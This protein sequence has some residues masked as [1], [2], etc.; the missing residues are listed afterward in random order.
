[1]SNTLTVPLTRQGG[2]SPLD[3][4]QITITVDD[5]SGAAVEAEEELGIPVPW[6]SILAVEGE[7]TRDNSP[8]PRI[9]PVNTL[10]WGELPIPFFAMGEIVGEGHDGQV[11]VGRI[12][13]IERVAVEDF[14]DPDFDL[15]RVPEG[16]QIIFARG[17]IQ[18]NAT[19]EHFLTLMRDKALRGVSIDMVSSQWAIA[20]GE[21]LEPVEDEF[22][23]SMEDVLS[24]DYVLALQAAEIG[25][26]TATPLQGIGTASISLT[27]AGVHEA[28][29]ET[30]F[31]IFEDAE[32]EPPALVAAAPIVHRRDAF[33]RPEPDH[34]VP[35][36]VDGL[37]VYGHAFVWD[38][39]HVGFQ[40]TCQKPKPS[41]TGYAN[42]H[43][44]R[45]STLEGEEVWVGQVTLDTDHAVVAP[46]VTPE[47]VW[48]HYSNTGMAVADV[49]IVDGRIGGWV[50][51][52]M[53]AVPDKD[54]RTLQAAK[55]SGD[56]RRINGSLD[57]IGL[58]AVNVPGFPVPQPQAWLVASAAGDE[59]Q[60]MV[61]AG[62]PTD[63]DEMDDLLAELLDDEC[64]PCEHDDL[65]AELAA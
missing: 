44:G 23:L 2:I 24:G 55:L 25:G 53:R 61:A 22:A 11:L 42:F 65:L 21:T 27:A 18:N 30:A 51:G 1:M 17:V 59:I 39:C 38:T 43:L 3:Q 10:T 13:T 41:P 5:R 48:E 31:G 36:T 29:L 57:L 4:L 8:M 60:A 7:L 12:D 56:W 6:K 54:V 50:S 32:P 26:A 14:S 9:L 15:S 52:V 47:Q 45:V 40:H 34:Y 37:E 33:Y 16:G 58:L 46:G 63:Y 49:R 20:H 64:A 62:I 28:H 35:L 19:T